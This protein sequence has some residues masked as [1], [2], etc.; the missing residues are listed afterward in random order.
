MPSY[1]KKIPHGRRGPTYAT[2][3]M[4]MNQMTMEPGIMITDHLVQTLKGEVKS[5]GHNRGHANH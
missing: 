1:S 4:Y 3:G 5:V 2:S